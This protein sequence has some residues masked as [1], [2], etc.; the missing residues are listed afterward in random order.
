MTYTRGRL[1]EEREP[2]MVYHVLQGC[3]TPGIAKSSVPS[4]LSDADDILP[5]Q[6][7]EGDVGRTR[8]Q[9]GA[10]PEA[11]FVVGSTNTCSRKVPDVEGGKS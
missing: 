7:G 1:E 8:K 2:K 6:K 10:R 4:V 9:R 5:G 11:I 3:S